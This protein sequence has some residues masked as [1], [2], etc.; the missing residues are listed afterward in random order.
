MAKKKQELQLMQETVETRE[1][2]ASDI[3]VLDYINQTILVYDKDREDLAAELTGVDWVSIFISLLDHEDRQANDEIYVVNGYT[4]IYVKDFIRSPI[5]C[6][7]GRDNPSVQCS[8]DLWNHFTFDTKAQIT[9]IFDINDGS[10]KQFYNLI[11]ALD[12]LSA[13]YYNVL[14]VPL[15][16]HTIVTNIDYCVFPIVQDNYIVRL[17]SHPVP[18]SE[19]NALAIKD[20]E[21]YES[22]IEESRE[23]ELNQLMEEEVKQERQQFEIDYSTIT[24][25]THRFNHYFIEQQITPLMMADI[26]VNGTD[27]DRRVKLLMDPNIL[28]TKKQLRGWYEV[29]EDRLNCLYDTDNQS[30]ALEVFYAF[31][32]KCGMELAIRSLADEGK[33]KP[34]Y[35]QSEK[36]RLIFYLLKTDGKTR[37]DGLGIT[38]ELYCDNKLANDWFNSISVVIGS[39]NH[40]AMTKLHGLWRGMTKRKNLL[41][42][43]PEG[44]GKHIEVYPGEGECISEEEVE[45]YWSLTDIP[46]F[47]TYKDKRYLFIVGSDL[48]CGCNPD[49]TKSLDTV[50]DIVNCC[51]HWID[52]ALKYLEMDK[53]KV[54]FHLIGIKDPEIAVGTV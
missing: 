19:Y 42:D 15:G 33:L 31:A 38:E 12:S 51:M 52:Q 37:C 11:T 23:L 18:W 28:N 26:L 29:L 44:L 6:S 2:L 47:I 20:Y 46:L 10:I 24:P 5:Q 25:E 1:M 13:S 43:H 14:A 8:I 41:D 27:E 9:E 30:K 40:E 3:L 32:D 16:D 4:F 22:L 21:A 17:Q 34:E 39:D 49:R 36:A 54:T 45:E 50:Q 53:S 48:T 35:F 7:L